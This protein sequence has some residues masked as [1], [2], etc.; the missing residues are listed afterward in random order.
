METQ[1]KYNLRDSKASTPLGKMLSCTIRASKQFARLPVSQLAKGAR[2]GPGGLSLAPRRATA[3]R[4][5]SSSS[6]TG[7]GSSSITSGATAAGATKTRT[8]DKLG[9]A[10]FGSLVSSRT[11]LFI[12][13]FV[14]SQCNI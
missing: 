8:V 13:F 9:L 2:S 1:W 5:F 11:F 10:L 3:Q 12:I 6:G 14:V 7:T 4:C